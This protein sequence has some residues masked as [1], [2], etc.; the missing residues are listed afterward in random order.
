MISGLS[1]FYCFAEADGIVLTS[2]LGSFAASSVTAGLAAAPSVSSITPSLSE[3]S[4]GLTVMGHING[5]DAIYASAL[6]VEV[7]AKTG[8]KMSEL[9]EEIQDK[10][11]RYRTEVRN[12]AFPAK[13]RE[14][15]MR[16][17]Y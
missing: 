4:G 12:I 1:D 8:R 6:L 3:S 16:R 14:E 2:G 5:K 17:I 13:R 10:F 9:L 11:G 7:I 15:L